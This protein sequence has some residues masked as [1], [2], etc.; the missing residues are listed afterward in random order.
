MHELERDPRRRRI[1]LGPPLPP[2]M[3]Q[4]LRPARPG[5]E[6]WRDAAA[7]KAEKLR[8]FH[9]NEGEEQGPFGDAIT[10]GDF[11]FSGRGVPEDVE[12]RED[13]DELARRMHP[14]DRKYLSEK[15][16][17]KADAV[18]APAASQSPAHRRFIS[19]G[20]EHNVDPVRL[21]ELARQ[22]LFHQQ[23]TSNKPFAPVS[24]MMI[25]C[26]VHH[27]ARNRGKCLSSGGWWFC[28]S[29]CLKPSDPKV[30]GP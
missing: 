11:L 2:R 18:P 30:Y 16:H 24:R 6:P 27:H 19:L 28:F 5:K 22:V 7:E 4:F 29:I 3:M 26:R 15:M 10:L 9:W 13:I 17:V 12:A 25:Y 14:M 23:T 20:E 8:K 21:A 1:D